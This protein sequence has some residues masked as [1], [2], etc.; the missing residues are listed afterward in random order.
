MENFKVETYLQLRP[1]SG[2]KKQTGKLLFQLLLTGAA[3]L[4]EMAPV[5]YM[6][7]PVYH[8]VLW[9]HFTQASEALII[10]GRDLLAWCYR[11]TVFPTQVPHL[12]PQP[13]VSILQNSL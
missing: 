8:Q 11:I 13:T 9:G 12:P 10:H 3:S 6:V 5:Q 7:T 1:V 4:M 2:L